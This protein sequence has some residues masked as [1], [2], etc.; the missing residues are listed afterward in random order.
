MKLVLTN[1]E[2]QN[3]N[4]T[5][6]FPQILPD[7]FFT[8]LLKRCNEL[9]LKDK[10]LIYVVHVE[11][12]DQDKLIIDLG[13]EDNILDIDGIEVFSAGIAEITNTDDLTIEWSSSLTDIYLNDFLMECNKQ[14]LKGFEID[15][16][17][18]ITAP[19]AYS[20][21]Y[22]DFTLKGKSNIADKVPA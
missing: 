16:I 18:G 14:G 13:Y 4:L 10:K 8:R 5:E 19:P 17:F 2:V 22:I 21:R 12:P 6:Y 7:T 9:G 1:K 15:N 20:Q 11:S 3:L